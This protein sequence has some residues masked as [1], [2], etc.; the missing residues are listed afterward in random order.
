MLVLVLEEVVQME[1]M[2]VQP[3]KTLE[4]V[5]AE[6]VRPMELQIHS[7]VVV[8]VPVLFSLHTHNK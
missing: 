8:V 3:H 5:V 2:E 1:V 6:Q 7:L 4:L